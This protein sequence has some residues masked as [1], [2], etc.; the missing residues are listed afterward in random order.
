V[1]DGRIL[2]IEHELQTLLADALDGRVVLRHCILVLVQELDTVDTRFL[3]GVHGPDQGLLR[4]ALDP[5][6]VS[7]E[8]V[9]AEL[10]AP[11]RRRG[12]NFGHL[13]ERLV[14]QFFVIL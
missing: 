13:V 11:S 7:D 4:H 6:F 8:Q 1:F 14:Q 12:G 10:D 9:Q 3:E 5:G 2:R